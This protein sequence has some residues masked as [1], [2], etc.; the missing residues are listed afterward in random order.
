MA[1]IEQIVDQETGAIHRQR[2]L[3][4]NKDFIQLKEQHMALFR[5]LNLKNHKAMNF[6]MFMLEHMNRNNALIV[7]RE[8]LAEIFNVST[9]TIDRW[10]KFCKDNDLLRTARTGSSNI[11]HVNSTIAWKAKAEKRKFAQFT[12]E[13][14]V[15]KSEQERAIEK[16]FTKEISLA[17]HLKDQLS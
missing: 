2:K 11:Y 7:S 6:L 12:A 13:V 1:L 14:I 10:V 3:S 5:E 15:S 8:T 16:A 9:P 17:Q 4:Q